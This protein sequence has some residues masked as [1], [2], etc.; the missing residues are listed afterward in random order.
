[1]H[2]SFLKKNV[3]ALSAEF[4]ESS[5]GAHGVLRES[6]YDVNYNPMLAPT[7]KDNPEFMK[8]PQSSIAIDKFE[9]INIDERYLQRLSAYIQARI[10]S[11]IEMSSY[12]VR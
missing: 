4:I 10:F 1:M 12:V 11:S 8:N 6:W 2:L 9:S 3:I 5:E 7:M